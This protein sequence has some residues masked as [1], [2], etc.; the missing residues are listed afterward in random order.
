MGL[1]MYLGPEAHRRA[2]LACSATCSRLPTR[3][4]EYTCV[5]GSGHAFMRGFHSQL[6]DAV[7]AC[8]ELGPANAP[9]CAQGAFHDYWISLGGGDGTSAPERRATTR[10]SRVCGAYTYK[11]PCWYR[12]FWERKAVARV[13]EAEDMLALCDGLDGHAARRLHRRRVA[14]RLARARS[15]RPRPRLRRARGRGHVQLPPRAQRARRSTGRSF[16]Q[17]RLIRD[18]RRPA[19]DDALV[20]LRLV[21]PH[22]RRRSRTAR[23]ARAGAPKLEPEHARVSCAAGGAHMSAAAADLLLES[24]C[25][26]ATD[27][28]PRA[29]TRRPGGARTRE[30]SAMICATSLRQLARTSRSGRGVAYAWSLSG[31]TSCAERTEQRHRERG[32]DADLA[33]AAAPSG[34]ACATTTGCSS[35]S[36][37]AARSS[38][39]NVRT[40]SSNGRAVGAAREVRGDHPRL[41]LR[42]LAVEHERDL[43]PDAVADDGTMDH[44]HVASDDAVAERVRSTTVAR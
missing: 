41:E 17:L 25:S 30:P 33:R 37:G 43:R 2:A 7:N 26:T 35:G 9:D 12:Y 27:E 15:G 23:S 1:V 44:A 22:A 10:P 40:S 19:D 4:R 24:A 39:V 14:A 5:H 29:G 18:L 20:V 34:A 32:R 13:Y 21:R 3:F 42:Q 6:R 38:A 36:S 16:E 31:V 28:R 8:N 11:R